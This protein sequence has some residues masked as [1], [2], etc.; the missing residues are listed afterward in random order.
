MPLGRGQRPGYSWITRHQVTRRGTWEF[1]RLFS[2]NDGFD[3]VLRVVP[4]SARFPAQAVI[5][6][7]VRGGSPA[8]LRIQG[9]VFAPRIEQLLAGLCQAVRS[10]DQEISKI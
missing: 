8:V 6:N 7:Q 2:R 5:E 4:G 3:L 1:H 9:I 10:T